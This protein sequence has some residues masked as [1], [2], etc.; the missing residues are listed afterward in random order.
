MSGDSKKNNNAAIGLDV[1][2]SRIVMAKLSG[3]E[4]RVRS[5]LN[6]F[7]TVPYSRMTEKALEKEGIPYTKRDE[8]LI[9][10]GNESEHFADLLGLETR[11]PM[12]GGILN[13]AEPEN[14]DV[15]LRIVDSLLEDEPPNGQLLYFSV[16]APPLEG[17]DNIAFHEATLRDLL[18]RRGFK[19][20]CITE[21]LAVVY[22]ELENTNYTGIGISFGGGLCNVCLSYLA[23]PVISFSVPKGGDFI[24]LNAAAVT[25]ER[26]T[27]V[28]IEKETAFQYNGAVS[29][30][31]H[32]A[33]AVYYDNVIQAVVDGLRESLSSSR[34]LPRFRQPVPIV[35]SGGTAH[36]K[37]FAQRFENVLKSGGFP[38]P[39]SGITVAKD[40]LH[41]TAK[42]AL[43]AALADQ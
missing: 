11:R 4:N 17:E 31:L 28:R 19:V 33:L 24:D 7:V 29:G 26:A 20:E 36:P 25:G 6:A 13:P 9:V 14:S 42:G 22:S 15:I 5:Q 27:R 30:K 41:S 35:L 39:Y 38:I 23:V 2:T 21:G 43:V 32:Q 16:P 34:S 1:G 37:G 8:E 40:P 12:T 3:G 10:H 18:S